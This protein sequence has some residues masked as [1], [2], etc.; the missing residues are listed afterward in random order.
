MKTF[1][2]IALISL[3]LMTAMPS[4]AQVSF[5]FHYG[6]PPPPRREIIIERPYPDAVW[7]PGYYD[8]IG[9]RYVWTPGYWRRPYYNTPHYWTPPG[10][11]YGWYHERGWEPHRRDFDDDHDHGRG[12]GRER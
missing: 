5:D 9:Y 1:L 12:R 8:R 11:H 2:K 3:P 10:H 6:Y 4:F 7:I